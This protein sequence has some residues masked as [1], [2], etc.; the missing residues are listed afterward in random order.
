VT[1]KRSPGR[2]EATISQTRIGVRQVAVRLYVTAPPPSTGA[3]LHGGDTPAQPVQSLVL[4]ATLLAGQQLCHVVTKG[5]DNGA[6]R[7]RVTHSTK[8]PDHGDA[9][10][11]RVDRLWTCPSSD[12]DALPATNAQQ[13][14]GQRRDRVGDLV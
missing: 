6:S 11:F 3:E 2:K 5:D 10:L 4:R 1:A 7:R 9:T 13:R 14:V 12:D 8:K